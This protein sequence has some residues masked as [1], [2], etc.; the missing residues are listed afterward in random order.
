MTKVIIIKTLENTSLHVI[1]VGI[2]SLSNVM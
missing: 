1:I 2:N